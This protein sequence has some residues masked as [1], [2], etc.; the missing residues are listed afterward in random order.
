MQ[1][2]SAPPT[3]FQE[4][5]SRLSAGTE[6]KPAIT[7]PETLMSRTTEA[8]M[9]VAEIKRLEKAENRTSGLPTW[10]ENIKYPLSFV[11][12]ALIGMFGVIFAKYV[13]VTMMSD[14]ASSDSAGSFSMLGYYLEIAVAFAAALMVKEIFRVKGEHFRKAQLVGVLF[15]V[16]MMHNFAFWAPGLFSKIYSPQW[17]EQTT[18]YAVANSFQFRGNYF[19]FSEEEKQKR[20]KVVRR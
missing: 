4:R 17:V 19:V 10:R 14:T 9:R 18:D 6:E 15:M 1:Q 13:I 8:T 2:S 7:A 3:S 20:P 12:A 16:G 5:L 11:K